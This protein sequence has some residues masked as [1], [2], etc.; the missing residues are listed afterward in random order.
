MATATAGPAPTF[1]HPKMQRLVSSPLRSPRR[2]HPGR[3]AER[4]AAGW[5]LSLLDG[6]APPV[7]ARL[8][9]PLVAVQHVRVQPPSP[10]TAPETLATPSL[11]PMT[12][13]SPH[14]ALSSHLI[15]P[16][17]GRGHGEISF[18]R[19][20]FKRRAMEKPRRHGRNLTSSIQSRETTL[21]LFG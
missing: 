11:P 18:C 7:G 19:Y 10:S 9:P 15:S 17:E 2:S 8:I 21:L 16:R 1:L 14:K 3:A 6:Q 4:I 5:I 20:L 13:A 12:M